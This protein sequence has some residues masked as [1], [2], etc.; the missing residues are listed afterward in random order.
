ML[1]SWM[2]SP[3][4]HVCPQAAELVI[5]NCEAYEAH[6]RDVRDY[7][8]ERLEVSGKAGLPGRKWEVGLHPGRQESGREAPEPRSQILAK[9]A[10]DDVFD[11]LVQEVRV[12]W[13]A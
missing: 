7:L 10:R 9:C 12:D 5:Q 13:C 6:M 4:R 3:P 2:G 8:E 11:G 1:P